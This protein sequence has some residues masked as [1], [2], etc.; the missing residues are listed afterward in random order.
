VVCGGRLGFMRI[1]VVLAAL[2]SAPLAGA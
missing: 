1:L 2:M